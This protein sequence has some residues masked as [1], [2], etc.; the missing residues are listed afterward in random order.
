MFSL[1][2]ICVDFCPT[3]LPVEF[4]S[5]AAKSEQADLGRSPES[6]KIARSFR[7]IPIRHR[8]VCLGVAQYHLSSGIIDIVYLAN[9]RMVVP[10]QESLHAKIDAARS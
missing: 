8:T 9:P 10:K 6:E 1:F 4:R 2:A 5:F 3:N 7:A